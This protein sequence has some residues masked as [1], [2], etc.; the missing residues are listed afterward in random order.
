MSYDLIIT[1]YDHLQFK[2]HHNKQSTES[3]HMCAY[4]KIQLIEIVVKF[5]II[6]GVNRKEHYILPAS[7]Y[8][9]HTSYILNI[10]FLLQF[11]KRLFIYYTTLP[12]ANGCS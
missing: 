12:I 5:V 7:I 6:A 4:V 3:I 9:I 8:L 2:F 1:C 10:C 11:F